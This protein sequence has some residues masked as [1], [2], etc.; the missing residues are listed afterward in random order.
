[1]D[2]AA[3]ILTLFMLLA[4]RYPAVVNAAPA[5]SQQPSELST[6]IVT[7]AVNVSQLGLQ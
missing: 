5:G 3:V 2:K 7:D 6:S 4:A 1:M